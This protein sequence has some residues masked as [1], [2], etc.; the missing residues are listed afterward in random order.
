M[1]TFSDNH[2]AI[3]EEPVDERIRK[4]LKLENY[5][6]KIN[7]HKEIDS[8]YDS[9]AALSSL[10]SLYQTMSRAEV[11]REL[12]REIDF[13]KSRYIEY[14]KIDGSDKIKLNSIM[15]KQSVILNTL[16]NLKANYLNDLHVDELFQHCVKHC[17][18][19]SSEL[20]YWLTRDHAYRQ[21]QINL[22]LEL[23]KP[24]ENSVH[25]CLDI[26]RK[27]SET[28]E[29]CTK[30]GIYIF[31][32][33]PEKKVRMLR[34]TMHSDNYFFPRVSVGPQRATVSFMTLNDNNK[35]IQ[36]KDDVTFVIDLCYI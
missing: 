20:D 18:T 4:F 8:I 33:D 9:L 31:K 29:E 17:D 2:A 16:H 3:Y 27:S 5:F 13:H 24:I 14:V 22:W 35:F 7:K 23:I 26:L 1:N 10:I 21:N 36:I 32:L 6:L 19:L 15:E 28:R 25:F 12:I 30:N 34:V 11:K